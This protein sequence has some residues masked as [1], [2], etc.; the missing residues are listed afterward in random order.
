MVHIE[1]MTQVV[2]MKGIDNTMCMSDTT[3]ID[4]K[5]CVGSKKF[6]YNT[7]TQK[8][9][10]KRMTMHMRSNPSEGVCKKLFLQDGEKEYSS[11]LV[12]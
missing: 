9:M 4:G 5:V 3:N 11:L 6:T 2:N 7:L 12:S 1:N 8:Y 10:F